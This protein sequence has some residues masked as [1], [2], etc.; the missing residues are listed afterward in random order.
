MRAVATIRMLSK[1]NITVTARRVNSV[2]L[3]YWKAKKPLDGSNVRPGCGADKFLIHARGRLPSTMYSCKSG[4]G[5]RQMHE[6]NNMLLERIVPCSAK[7]ESG[8]YIA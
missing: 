8:V 5:Y 4:E 6:G 7:R 2:G 1:G 3:S